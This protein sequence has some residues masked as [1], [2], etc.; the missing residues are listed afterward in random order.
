MRARHLIAA[1]AVLLAVLAGIDVAVSA[2]ATP[3]A[4]VVSDSAPPVA[5]LLFGGD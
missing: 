3:R 1:L 4:R 2:L 5:P